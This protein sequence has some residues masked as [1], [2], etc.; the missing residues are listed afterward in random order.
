VDQLNANLSALENIAFSQ[1]ELT[2]ID[3]ILKQ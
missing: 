3:E 2:A 1:D